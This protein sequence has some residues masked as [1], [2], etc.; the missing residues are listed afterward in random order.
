MFPSP[1]AGDDALYTVKSMTLYAR[2]TLELLCKKTIIPALIVTNDWFS[3]LIPGYVKNKTYGETF[4][5][6]QVFHVAHNLDTNYEVLVRSAF[7]L[8]LRH[9]ELL[10]VDNIRRRNRV[11]WDGCINY[12]ENGLLIQ[13]GLI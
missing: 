11:I 8:I 9:N 3:G 5:G 2:V 10:R 13:I 7:N 6:T 1:F 4:A 12:P